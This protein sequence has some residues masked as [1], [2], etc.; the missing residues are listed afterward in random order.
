MTSP[1][2]WTCAACH[3]PIDDGKGAVAA[4]FQAIRDHEP[5]L[6]QGWHDACRNLDDAYDIDV[7]RIRSI[8]DVFWWTQHLAGKNWYDRS[9]WPEMLAAHGITPLERTS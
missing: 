1:L 8:E 5:V 9:D 2:I 6:W 4:N 3:F 7:H